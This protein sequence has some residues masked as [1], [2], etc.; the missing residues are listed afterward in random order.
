MKNNPNKPPVPTFDEK[1]VAR[2]LR[3]NWIKT[4]AGMGLLSVL[5]LGALALVGVQFS[6]ILV[7]FGLLSV[8]L[9]IFSWYNSASLV[10]RLM[11][12]EKPNT[13]NPD[14]MRLVRLVDELFPLTGLKKKPEVMVSPIP[15]PNAFA[16][17]RNPEN[18]F[19]AATEG[20]FSCDLTDAEIKAVLAHELAH[21]KSHDVAITS[22]TSVLGS[23][24]AILLSTGF[25]RFFQSAFVGKNN[26]LLDKLSNKVKN[27]K[28]GFAAPA[29]GIVG[30]FFT[31]LLFWVISFFAKFVTLF[32]SR[33]RES[34]ADV[35]ATQWTGDPCSLST[36]LQ[37]IVDWTQRNALALRLRILLDG[38]SPLLF[39][40]LDEG[41]HAHST[42]DKSIGSRLGKW[43]QDIG[44]NHPPMDKRL[45]MLNVLAGET[46]PSLHALRRQDEEAFNAMIEKKYG[47][48]RNPRRTQDSAPDSVEGNDSGS[49]KGDDK[50]PGD[51]DVSGEDKK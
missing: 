24:F 26:D 15:V 39:V 3:N 14:H 48:L 6:F 33:S 25:P 12:C 34:A 35:L 46:C 10:K 30:F 42:S 49:P 44:A 27:N 5:S 37:K 47:K 19:I 8:V 17:G 28:K 40:S 21:V 2:E 31:L 18:S 4:F 20:L 9:P 38:M 36:A 22:F 45:E 51:G 13:F 7:I 50:T 1:A 43:W 16:T 29:V 41:K 23:L 11:R 32:V